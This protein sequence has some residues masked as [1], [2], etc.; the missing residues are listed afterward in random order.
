[1]GVKNMLWP[2]WSLLVMLCHFLFN[3][4]FLLEQTTVK[5]KKLLIDNK[6][7]HFIYEEELFLSDHK[8]LFH[9]AKLFY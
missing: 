2:L 3:V 9:E 7:N 6:L 4:I 5:V 8:D 1:M